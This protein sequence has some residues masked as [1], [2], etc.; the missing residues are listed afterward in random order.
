MT[1]ALRFVDHPAFHRASI[2]TA[3]GAA[4]GAAGATAL[5]GPLGLAA[6]ALVGGVVGALAGLSWAE[7]G[8][9][10]GRTGLRLCAAAAGL[11]LLATGQP[12]AAVA[13]ALALGLAIGSGRRRAAVVGVAG[14]VAGLVAAWASTRV[15][16]AQETASLA[17][18]L[19]GALAGAAVGLA[20]TLALAARH[21][22]L[23]PDPVAAA[24]R[25]LPPLAGEA[26]DLVER[27]RAIWAGTAELPVGDDNRELVKDGV[28]RLFGVAERLAAAP[29]VDGGGIERRIAELD[30]RIAGCGDAVAREQY[31]EARAALVDQ[32]RYVDRVG[33]AR[34]RIVARMHHCVATLETFKLACAQLDATAA[35]REAADARN[36]MSVLGELGEGLAI[37]AGAEGDGLSGLSASSPAAASAAAASPVEASAAAS[38]PAT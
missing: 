8:R 14:A 31:V 6:P 15:M 5:A 24:Y 26:R 35:A 13:L 17:P 10:A 36:A 28:L 32:R 29:A 30:H 22:T 23:A 21:L 1:T 16:G 25:A 18:P 37:A 19:T 2:A 20:T 34:E 38:S 3:L 12:A 11:A 33:A 9:S 4:A 7:T 27:G